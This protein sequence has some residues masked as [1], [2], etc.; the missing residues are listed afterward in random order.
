MIKFR[1]DDLIGLGLTEGNFSLLRE[2][3]PIHFPGE[4]VG[5]AGVSMLIFYG[6]TERDI[7][8]KLKRHGARLPK[9]V[10]F[11]EDGSPTERQS[12][13]HNERTR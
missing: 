3:K 8:Q 7:Y 12:F 4:E 13:R 1:A 9:G 2:D 6:R 5:L 11:H 10:T